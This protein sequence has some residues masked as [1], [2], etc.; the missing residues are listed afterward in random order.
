MSTTA[1]EWVRVVG[2]DADD[3][4]DHLTQSGQTGH[5]FSPSPD[6]SQQ[7][8]KP[9]IPGVTLAVT[10]PQ[11]STFRLHWRS[12]QSLRRLKAHVTEGSSVDAL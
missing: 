12:S 10:N 1:A 11:P 4:I 9:V 6:R 5:A 8:T 7:G 2:V 3:D